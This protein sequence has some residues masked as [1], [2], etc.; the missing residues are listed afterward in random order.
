MTRSFR[1]GAAFLFVVL[2]CSPAFAV[3]RHVL[4]NGLVV[5]LEEM[6]SSPVTGIYLWVRTGSATESPYIGS[7][8]THFVEHMLFKGTS[9]RGVGEIPREAKAM[10]G[11]INAATGYDHTVFYLSVPGENVLRGMDLLAD[12]VRAP[13]FDPAEVERER[14]VILKEGRM[15]RDNPARQFSEKARERFYQV[16]PYRYPIIGHEDLFRAITREDLAAYHAA[17]Y[18]PNNMILSVAGNIDDVEILAQARALLG[19][20]SR[21]SVPLRDLPDEPGKIFAASFVEEYPTDLFRMGFFYPGVPLAHPDLYAL[22]V[23]A[24]ALGDG[25]SS[26]LYRDLFEKRRLVDSVDAVNDTPLDRGYFG[27]TTVMREDRSV[28][29]RD[30]VLAIVQD[31]QRRGLRSDE[32]KKVRRQVEAMTIR[33]RETAEGMAHRMAMEEAFAGDALFSEKYLAGVRKV[34]NQDIRR[35]AREYLRSDRVTSVLFRPPQE[36]GKDAEGDLLGSPVGVEKKILS[37]GLTVL[38]GAD[39]S[40][41]LVSVRLFV[42]GGM[43]IDPLPLEGLSTLTARV[44][45]KAF[46]GKGGALIRR[47]IESRGG[48]FSVG[49]GYTADVLSFDCLSQDLPFFLGILRGFLLDPSF[50]QEDIIREKDRMLTALRARKDSV[51]QTGLQALKEELFLTHPVRRDP[52]GTEASLGAMTRQDLLRRYRATLDAGRMVL[53]VFGDFDPEKVGDILERDLSLIPGTSTEPVRSSEEP[54]RSPRLR[55]LR[56]DKEQAAVLYGLRGP[57]IYD[58]DLEAMQV[59]VNV[60]SSPLGGRMFQRIRDELGKAYTLGG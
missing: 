40:L 50:P 32:L 15:L 49:P 39:R 23:L 14:E 48:A 60:L 12:M 56:M 22:D 3:T 1:W 26:R 10:G 5:L 7:G 11:V 18:A 24:M 13:A 19:D 6:P 58:K 21:A 4:D 20:V 37:N 28:E 52:L 43:Q 33:A 2:F 38:M 44:W 9:R 46:A 25:E 59:A 17:Y 29:V 34:T 53:S 16:H 45:D 54:P 57:T 42:P 41:P 35:V 8:I 55:E 31:V 27:I 30:R 47:E 36:E 51:I